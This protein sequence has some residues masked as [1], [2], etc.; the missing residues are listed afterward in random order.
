MIKIFD[1]KCTFGAI[2]G[3]QNEE[4][5]TDA[6]DNKVVSKQKSLSQLAYKARLKSGLVTVDGTTEPFV[7]F[8]DEW[9]L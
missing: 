5:A 7:F 1:T 6:T 8:G 4:N 3:F 2:F 9:S